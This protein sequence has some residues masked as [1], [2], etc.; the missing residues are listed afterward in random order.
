MRTVEAEVEDHASHGGQSR[1]Q[2]LLRRPK[3]RTMLTSE[4]EEEDNAY[5]GGD[6]T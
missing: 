2:R 1:E 6:E 5:Y 3:K 4:A